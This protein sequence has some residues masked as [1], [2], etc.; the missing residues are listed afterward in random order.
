[1]NVASVSEELITSIFMVENQRTHPLH[2]GLLSGIFSTLTMEAISSSESSVHVQT[3][4][5]GIRCWEHRKS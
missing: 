3:T 5:S 1:M 4:R 2:A